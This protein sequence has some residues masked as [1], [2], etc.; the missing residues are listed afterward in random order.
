MKKASDMLPKPWGLDDA[1]RAYKGNTP[2]CGDADDNAALL[3][4]QQR[5]RHEAECHSRVGWFGL[6]PLREC[7]NDACRAAAALL[8]EADR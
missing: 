7:P 2:S 3:A 5:E 6:P 1:R 4:E 8:L